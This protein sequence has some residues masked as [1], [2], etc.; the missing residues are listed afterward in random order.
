MKKSFASK[1]N[2]FI[3]AVLKYH[4]GDLYSPHLFAAFLCR[5][6]YAKERHLRSLT[7]SFNILRYDILAASGAFFMRLPQQVIN[8]S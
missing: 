6:I 1:V 8:K 2:S 4:I 5:V 3:L 7:R